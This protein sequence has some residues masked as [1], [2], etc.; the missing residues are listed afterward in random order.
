MVV[1]EFVIGV[2]GANVCYAGCCYAFA[3]HRLCRL[4]YS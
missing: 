2:M 1:P 4:Q 3:I